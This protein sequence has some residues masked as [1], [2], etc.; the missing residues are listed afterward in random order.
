MTLALALTALRSRRARA[1][2]TSFGVR[3]FAAG[4]ITNTDDPR[5]DPGSV[6]IGALTH[7]FGKFFGFLVGNLKSIYSGVGQ[8][9]W[10][11]IWS[12]IVTTVRFLNNFNWNATD[13]ELDAQIQQGMVALASRSGGVSW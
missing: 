9:D 6:G 10:K 7:G 1:A 5:T 13:K 4:T 2:V 11:G 3:R 8:I 12:K